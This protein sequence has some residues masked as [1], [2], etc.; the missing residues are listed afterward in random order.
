MEE[1]AIYSA[2][3]F[4]CFMLNLNCSDSIFHNKTVSL[5]I[6]MNVLETVQIHF[7]VVLQQLIGLQ[8]KE[9]KNYKQVHS[10]PNP[11]GPHRFGIE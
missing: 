11:W 10:I 7:M 4:K 2:P 9:E 1:E 8:N 3:T 5:I 6:I